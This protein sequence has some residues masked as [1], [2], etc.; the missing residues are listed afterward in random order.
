[1]TIECAREARVINVCVEHQPAHAG[2]YRGIQDFARALGDDILSFDGRAVKHVAGPGTPA[3]HRI[4]AGRGWLARKVLTIN[5]IA[6]HEADAIAADADLLV[7]HSLFRAH[8]PW[9]RNWAVRH[10]RPYWVVPHGCLDPTGLARRAAGKRLW[11]WQHGGRLFAEAHALVFATRRERDKAAAW[12]RQHCGPHGDAGRPLSVVV[13][14]PVSLPSLAGVEAARET[15]RNRHDI[16]EKAPILLW[17]GR[18]HTM[19]R[20]LQAILAFAASAAGTGH[21]VIVGMD[22][23]LSR[24]GLQAKIPPAVAGRVHLVGELQGAALAE[25]WLAADGYISLSAKENFGYATADALAHGLPVILSPGH[26][27]AYELPGADRGGLDC[28]WLLPDDSLQSAVD[29]I[30]EWSALVTASGGTPRRLLGLRETGRIWAA[31]NLSF[32]RFRSSLERLAM[33]SIG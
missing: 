22:E 29:A 12:T 31:D 8:A 19:K 32:E 15:F 27:L 14:W 24:V 28:G 4:Q 5:S 33:A 3:I 20:P 2:L 18:L 10:G 7:T 25:A 17:V 6:A 1:M 30:G 13:P 23:N 9:A 16:P 11:L 21:L 26:D